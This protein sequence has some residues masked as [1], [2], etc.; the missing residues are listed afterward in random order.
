MKFSEGE[1]VKIQLDLS[2]GR[3]DMTCDS[4]ENAEDFQVEFQIQAPMY[5]FI[6]FFLSMIVLM[7]I[8]QNILV[9]YK[10]K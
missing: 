5:S 9:R 3:N 2:S 10:A 1:T 6:L 7:R 8:A 4:N